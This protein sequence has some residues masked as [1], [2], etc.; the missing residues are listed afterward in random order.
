MKRE[1]DMRKIVY[2]VAVS[3][4]MSLM[5]V[6]PVLA[7]EI[8]TEQDTETVTEVV[9]RSL[10]DCSYSNVKDLVYAGKRTLLKPEI[11]DGE[12]TLVEGQDYEC[13]YQNETKVGEATL[14][15]TGIGNY[16]GT[17]TFNYNITPKKIKAKVVVK[18]KS[19]PYAKKKKYKPEIVVKDGKTVIPKS[20]YKVTYPKTKGIGTYTIKVRL[21]NNYRGT[22]KGKFQLVPYNTSIAKLTG[23]K[24][25]FTILWKAMIG[26]KFN[27]FTGYEVVC[28][29]EKNFKHKKSYKC[30]KS[31]RLIHA[32]KLKSKKKYYVKMRTFKIEGK[33][34]YYFSSWSKVKTVKTK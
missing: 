23:T 8:T 18:K 7:E 27:N 3:L 25:G 4:A 14:T 5:A 12:I 11:K 26:E 10:E 22:G 34:K 21:K 2:G 9:V 17:R 6:A 1:N 32:G 13:S 19:F 16:S 28:S 29:T 24:K 33:K 15:V 30:S 20:N 31:F